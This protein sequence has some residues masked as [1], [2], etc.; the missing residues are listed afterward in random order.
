MIVK[1][2]LQILTEKWDQ[3]EFVGQQKKEKKN[4]FWKEGKPLILI[5]RH[6]QMIFGLTASMLADVCFLKGCKH[7]F[8]TRTNGIRQHGTKLGG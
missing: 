4:I 1:I 8:R 7:G 2:T 6:Q 5:G 3:K